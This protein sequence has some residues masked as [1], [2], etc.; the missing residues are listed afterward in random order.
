MAYVLLVRE[1]A[2]LNRIDIPPRGISIG[3]SGMVRPAKRRSTGRRPVIL[4]YR[5]VKGSLHYA[6]VHSPRTRCYVNGDNVLTLHCL[7]HRDYIVYGE[8]A[9]FFDSFTT[10]QPESLSGAHEVPCAYCRGPIEPGSVV[11]C[12]PNCGLVYHHAHD[13]SCWLADARCACGQKTDL[14][15]QPDWIPAGFTLEAADD[16][17]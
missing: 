15:Q 11:V 7:R 4:P 8:T 5:D 6:L 12:C 2:T 9:L 1:K 16:G 17:T 3:E 13:G 14:E 10:P